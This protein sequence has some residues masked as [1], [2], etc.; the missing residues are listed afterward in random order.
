M[1]GIKLEISVDYF[2][3]RVPL[4]GFSSSR[5]LYAKMVFGLADFSEFNFQ[6]LKKKPWKYKLLI[7]EQKKIQSLL[8]S[9][10]SKILF[11]YDVIN[12]LKIDVYYGDKE[13]Q[14]FCPETNAFL[15]PFLIDNKITNSTKEILHYYRTKDSW[16]INSELIDEQNNFSISKINDNCIES[17]YV[18]YLGLPHELL[19]KGKE[20]KVE[21]LLSEGKIDDYIFLQHLNI[22]KIRVYNLY[23]HSYYIYNHNTIIELEEQFTLLLKKYPNAISFQTITKLFYFSDNNFDFNDYNVNKLPESFI[24]N[25]SKFSYD[26]NLGKVNPV[27]SDEKRY[28]FSNSEPVEDYKIQR[29]LLEKR[30]REYRKEWWYFNKYDY[31]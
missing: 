26:I 23:Y 9:I 8:K 30:N 7:I 12:K 19:D 18:G 27:I 11:Q 3:L 17:S 10:K 20:I 31:L 13:L 25:P 1:K 5:K 29:E 24:K 15:S 4:I 28:N 14:L 6:E 2:T 21:I 22:I 16:N